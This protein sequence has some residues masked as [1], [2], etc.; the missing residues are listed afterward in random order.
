[1]G[2]GRF[3]LLGNL[4]QQLDI[5]D[6]NQEI[7]NLRRELVMSR[8]SAG[9]GKEDFER[10]QAENDEL[11]L[12][13]AAVVQLLVS[14]GVISRDEL[15]RVVDAVDAEDGEKDGRYNGPLK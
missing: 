11:R 10:L 13:L 14:K 12:Y 5:Q 4:G 2:W 8:A 15:R 7:Q 1:M 3:L 9:G 6:Q